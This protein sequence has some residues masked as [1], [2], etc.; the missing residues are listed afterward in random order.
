MSDRITQTTTDEEDAD[1]YFVRCCNE[2][3][4]DGWNEALEA[5]ASHLEAIGNYG[6]ESIAAGIR[7]MR[8]P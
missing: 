2:A 5:A 4:R 3:K 7:E 8:K 6:Y 1:D